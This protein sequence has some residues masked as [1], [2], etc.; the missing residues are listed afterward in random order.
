MGRSA[1]VSDQRW[2]STEDNSFVDSC[3][4]S[5]GL[6]LKARKSIKAAQRRVETVLKEQ[7]RQDRHT[8]ENGDGWRRVDAQ[9]ASLRKLR[10]SETATRAAVAKLERQREA[11]QVRNGGHQSARLQEAKRMLA[12][13]PK[14]ATDFERQLEETLLGRGVDKHGMRTITEATRD[15]IE[16]GSIR[17]RP[18]KDGMTGPV[19]LL[20]LGSRVLRPE[21]TARGAR[22]R[23][24]G[25]LH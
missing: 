9:I 5:K 22:V 16:G 18:C 8:G 24:S 11:L 17:M 1:S 21:G 19:E 10:M 4:P 13:L 6:S 3:Q 7:E 20:G 2:C 14:F 23:G 12:R 25:G 15:L